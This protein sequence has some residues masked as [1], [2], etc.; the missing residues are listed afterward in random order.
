VPF[1]GRDAE[2]RQVVG[3]LASGRLT[4]VV[5]APGLGK[6]ALLDEGVAPALETDGWIVVRFRDWRGKNA[7]AELK[8]AMDAALGESEHTG[9]PVAVLLDQ[10]EDSMRCHAGANEELAEAIASRT[11]AFAVGIQEHAVEALERFGPYRRV[12]LGPLDRDTA[13]AVLREMGVAEASIPEL[14]DAL[15]AAFR[16]G[17]HPFFLVLGAERLLSGKVALADYGGA[18]RLILESLDPKLGELNSTHSE[19]FFRWCNVL[20]SPDNLAS[21]NGARQAVTAE[22]LTEY[23]GKLN[24]FALSL[25]PALEEAGVLRTI[26]GRY[27]IARE[28]YTPLIRDWWLRKEAAAIARD[29]ARFRVRSVSLAVGAMVLVY[30]LWLA[31]TW[32]G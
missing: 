16:G 10:F 20:I 11:A 6:T 4:A 31:L 22:A 29:R 24:R 1:V 26:G 13:V 2:V 21:G 8:E 32:K 12:D 9:R 18:D 28:C 23:S 17:V 19:L 14:A 5:S 27:E 25:M 30:A 3:H 15:A 7:V